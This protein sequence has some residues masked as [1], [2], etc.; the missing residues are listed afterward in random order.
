MTRP[1]GLN[2]ALFGVPEADGRSSADGT[3][4]LEGCDQRL[5]SRPA[6]VS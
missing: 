1:S 6:T 3:L 2:A 5:Q 4:E